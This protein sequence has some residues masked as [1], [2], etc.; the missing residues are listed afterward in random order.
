M[1]EKIVSRG[2]LMTVAVLIVTVIGV[3]AATRI[4][5]QMIPDLDVRTITVRTA[6]PGAT[7]QDVEKEILIEQE[8]FLRNVP[9]LQRLVANASFG[10]ATIE[11]E[12][13]YGVDINE[14]LIRVSNALSQVPSYP[15]NA[16][17]P[18]IFATSFSSNSFMFF[19]VAPLAGNP[20][21]LNMVLMQD[22]LEDNVQTRME[23]IPGVSQVSVY[24]G[25]ERQI[26]ILL[27]PARLAEHGLSVTDVR[28]AI[29]ERNRD[30]SGGEI[31]SG[32]RRYLLRT[33][34]R[35][36][37][38]DGLR[39][40]ILARRGDAL[41]RLGDLAEV[42]LSHFELSG[43]SFS[44]GQPVL[45]LSVR[46]EAGS[47]VIEIKRA[48]L[49]ELDEINRE[50]LEPAGMVMR[51]V[52]DDVGYVEASLHNVWKNLL[53]GAAL[54][55][56]VMFLFLRSGRATL[57]AVMG[58]PICTIAA[59]LGLL[60]AGR[61]INVISLAG[62]AFAIGMTLDNSIV[63]LES[64]EQ[65]RR[66]GLDRFRSAVEGVRQVWP[67]VLASTL[68]TVLVF[69]PIVFIEQEA[70]QLYSDIAIAVS[71]SILASMLVAITVLPTATAHMSF[72][73]EAQPQTGGAARNAVLA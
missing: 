51:L 72:R 55:S 15:N 24:G 42:K 62:V 66:R 27:D 43:R 40:L 6:W 19:R 9:S 60:L 35:F 28:R 71:A 34:G 56:A 10:Q 57:V 68:T 41:I 53:I 11:L 52:A 37:D 26:Q 58:I 69:V 25:A 12:F 18:R 22:F 31:E 17:E 23:S 7:P 4:S 50:V 36:E 64:I 48:M 67:A 33:I 65:A 16:D 13:P 63:V 49:D 29:T 70:G 8:E 14:T 5:V 73:N 2:T 32:K 1:F 39:G 59:F 61:T 21:H 45:G 30:A 44:D 38:L 47:N 46:R 20:R 54:A 3:V